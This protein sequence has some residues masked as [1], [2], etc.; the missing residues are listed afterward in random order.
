MRY[1][2]LRKQKISPHCFVCGTKN[3]FGL[4]ASFYECER[5]DG[6]KV[7]LAVFK[8]HNLHQS[9]PSRMHGGIISTILDE[10]I[11]RAL[12]MLHTEPKWGVTIDLNIKFRKPVPL[13]EEIYCETKIIKE[14]HRSFEGEGKL[15][16]KDGTICATAIGKYLILKLEQILDTD[17]LS[18]EV[19][20]YI[21]EPLPKEF[22]IG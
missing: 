5:E 13:E 18:D 21:N 9:Y 2:V 16:T 10:A 7:L 3:N 1:K 12:E 4:Q 20:V 19:L 15:M 14:T 11:G 22:I 6:E 17:K 8:G